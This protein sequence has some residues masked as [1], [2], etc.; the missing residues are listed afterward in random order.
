VDAAGQISFRRQLRR[1]EV[2]RF[3]GSLRP[4][5]T[6]WR[7][8]PLETKIMAWYRTDANLRRPSAI[9]GV[10]PITASAVAAGAAG[11]SL[12]ESGRQFASLIG[13]TPR[14]HSSGG[15]ESMTGISKLGGRLPAVP[16]ASTRVGGKR[17]CQATALRPGRRP[18]RPSEELVEAAGG[19]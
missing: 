4:T 10:G 16:A 1:G 19:C 11:A 14:A 17:C 15:N 6:A 18:D 12:F 8:A 7:L 2:L 3:F 9:P 13:L 5:S